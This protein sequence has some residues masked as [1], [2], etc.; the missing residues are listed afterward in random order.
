[1]HHTYKTLAAMASTYCQYY[2]NEDDL[3]N[4]D[5]KA[6]ASTTAAEMAF[7]RDPWSAGLWRDLAYLIYEGSAAEPRHFLESDMA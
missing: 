1:M 7:T 2:N 6:A 5:G 4:M 3:L